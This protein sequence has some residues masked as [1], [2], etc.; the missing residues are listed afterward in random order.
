MTAELR[1]RFLRDEDDLGQLV[2][3]VRSGAYGGTGAAYFS[4]EQVEKFIQAL[5]ECPLAADCPPKI[6]GGRWN[7]EDRSELQECPGRG[8]SLQPSWPAHGAGGPH[9][10]GPHTCVQ[11]PATIRQRAISDG[12]C[13]AGRFR[14]RAVVGPR[15]QARIC[16]PARD[17][18]LDRSSA[19]RST[20]APCPDRPSPS[21]ACRPDGRRCARDI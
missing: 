17:G 4:R 10:R 1:M 20:A 19:F 2:A 14:S 7:K 9:N 21:P 5:R 12:I 13:G 15:W 6:E 18:A 11:R 16:R 3:T 8:P